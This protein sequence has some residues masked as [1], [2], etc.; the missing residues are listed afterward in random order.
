MQVGKRSAGIG[1]SD[2]M[3][4]HGQLI[5]LLQ[6]ALLKISSQELEIQKLDESLGGS[7][8]A[9]AELALAL[10]KVNL[11]EDDIEKT[12]TE[13]DSLRTELREKRDLVF[14][15]QTEADVQKVVCGDVMT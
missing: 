5:I 9:A 3:H 10:R 1:G 8:E 2:D 4:V 6:D 11:L 15:L 13:S 12:I 7:N 14:K